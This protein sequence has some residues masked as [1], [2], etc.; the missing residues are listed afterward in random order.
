[1]WILMYIMLNKCSLSWLPKIHCVIWIFYTI[2]SS[3]VRKPIQQRAHES[4]HLI[5]KD[6]IGWFLSFLSC[7]DVVFYQ[8]KGSPVCSLRTRLYLCVPSYHA[9]PRWGGGGQR[10]DGDGR[11]Q[12]LDHGQDTVGHVGG[13]VAL[14]LPAVQLRRQQVSGLSGG[15]GGARAREP[16]VKKKPWTISRN[17]VLITTATGEPCDHAFLQ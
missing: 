14:V 2:L 5:W 6:V 1:M 17:W 11:L 8:T 15:E 9:V 12:S 16:D 3:P 4:H 10:C 7:R 13:V